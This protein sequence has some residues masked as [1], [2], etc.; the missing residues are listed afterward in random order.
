[1]IDFYEVVLVFSRVVVVGRVVWYLQEWVG[2]EG[3]GVDIVDRD[4]IGFVLVGWVIYYFCGI[5]EMGF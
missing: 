4:Q 1:M 2:F 5:Y 3:G